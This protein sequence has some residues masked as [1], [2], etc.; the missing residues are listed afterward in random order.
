MLHTNILHESLQYCLVTAFTLHVSWK[1]SNFRLFIIK[2]LYK[3]FCVNY[4]ILSFRFSNLF[5]L[6]ENLLAKLMISGANVIN[7]ISGIGQRE[8]LS[9]AI[10]LY[11][12]FTTHV[13]GVF[14][15][16]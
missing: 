6:K 15:L 16:T 11:P 9:R 8:E 12:T 5:S 4:N 13:K 14:N 7:V 3:T 10:R 2:S 1:I